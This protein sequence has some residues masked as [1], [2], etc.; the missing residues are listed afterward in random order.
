[1]LARDAPA[2]VVFGTQVM[3]VEEDLHAPVAGAL[4]GEGGL[5]KLVVDELA[6][7]ADAA[8]DGFDGGEGVARAEVGEPVDVAAEAVGGDLREE[9]VDAIAGGVG[10]GGR[11][12]AVLRVRDR[13]RAPRDPHDE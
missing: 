10:Q 2:R 7:G 1:D 8:V 11:D 9:R 12:G 6:C 5:E 13:S 4:G 3:T